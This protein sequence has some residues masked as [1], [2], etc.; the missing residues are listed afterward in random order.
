MNSFNATADCD[1]RPKHTVS[2]RAVIVAWIIVVLAI[3]CTCFLRFQAEQASPNYTEVTVRVESVEKESAPW[4]MHFFNRRTTS[5]HSSYVVTVVHNGSKQKLTDSTWVAEGS[6]VTAYESNGKLYASTGSIASHTF[7]GHMYF[8]GLGISFVL[9]IVALTITTYYRRGKS[10]QA[11]EHT[12][13]NLEHVPAASSAAKTARAAVVAETVSQPSKPT[14]FINLY[15]GMSSQTGEKVE[16]FTMDSVDWHYDDAVEAYCTRYHKDPDHLS[17]ED[18]EKIWEGAAL[19]MSYFISWLISRD[20]IA[21]VDANNEEEQE[22]R[23]S[24]RRREDTPSLY[25]NAMLDERLLHDDIRWVNGFVDMYYDD[26]YL[27]FIEDYF[28]KQGKL[29]TSLFSWQECDEVC[30]HIESDYRSFIKERFL[31]MGR[32]ISDNDERVVS[33]MELFFDQ[34]KEFLRTYKDDLIERAYIESEADADDFFTLD[35]GLIV[36]LVDLLSS[37]KY[38]CELDWKETPDELVASLSRMR[39]VEDCNI[40]WNKLEQKLERTMPEGEIETWSQAIA[41]SEL[42]PHGFSLGY[43]DT[44][45]DEY[46]FFIVPRTQEQEIARLAHEADVKVLFVRSLDNLSAIVPY[47]D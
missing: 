39:Q 18:S 1:K 13:A 19:H 32:I 37:T 9:L 45:S 29:Y 46:S 42:M 47:Q 7:I 30:A 20:C 10:M 6:T 38:A 27:P 2:M 21:S 36:L 31:N 43:F 26:V 8:A 15:D 35:G 11:E 25:L 12:T 5:I 33:A 23:T 3:V 17:D 16:S 34:P 40:D 24:V 22:L 41:Q 44:D 14:P 4:W 28:N